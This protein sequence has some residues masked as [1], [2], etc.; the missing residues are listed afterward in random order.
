MSEHT[1]LTV[2]VVTIE[3]EQLHETCDFVKCFSSTGDLGVYPE[4]TSA[5]ILLADT[6]L[7]LEKNEKESRY[8]VSE[9]ILTVKDNVVTIMTDVLLTKND[10]SREELETSVST[11]TQ[12]YLKKSTYQGQEAARKERLSSEAKLRVLSA[13]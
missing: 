5:V 6:D 2:S 3:G 13:E 7:V 9:G 12:A 4:H 10:L 1:Q 11:A 8:F